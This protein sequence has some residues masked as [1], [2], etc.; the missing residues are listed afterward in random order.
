[1]FSI[2]THEATSL[3]NEYSPGLLIL[4]KSEPSLLGSIASNSVPLVSSTYI[5]ALVHCDPSNHCVYLIVSATFQ[6]GFYFSL[7]LIHP[8]QWYTETIKSTSAQLDNHFSLDF[9][10]QKNF[11]Y[12]HFTRLHK[13]SRARGCENHSW[14]GDA[15]VVRVLSLTFSLHLLYWSLQ[16]PL[17][18]YLFYNITQCH[19]PRP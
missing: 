6:H 10:I 17:R 16:E 5:V 11:K 1:M 3:L 19:C 9:K 8:P 4:K 7:T 13:Q 14:P 18:I 15:D 2:P 12:L